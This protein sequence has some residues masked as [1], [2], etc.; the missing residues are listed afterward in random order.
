MDFKFRESF[1]EAFSLWDSKPA[2]KTLS[3]KA[4]VFQFFREFQ[5]ELQKIPFS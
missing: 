5:I 3:K 1:L 2:G 4:P